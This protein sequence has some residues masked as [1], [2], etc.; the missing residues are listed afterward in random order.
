M[1]KFITIFTI[2]YLSFKL[3]LDINCLIANIAIRR[4]SNN[5]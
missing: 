3:I 2:I 4:F 1:F 5:N